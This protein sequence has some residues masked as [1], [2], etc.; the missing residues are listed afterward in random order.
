MSFNKILGQEAAIQ[1]LRGQ[2]KKGRV[3]HTY[4]FA[5]PEGIGKRLLAIEMAKALSC[6]QPVK[7]E[8]CD[9]CD[10]CRKIDGG[11]APNLICVSAEKGSGQIGI[12]PIRALEHGMS[13]TSYGGGWKIGMV[14]GAERLT[15]EAAN[16]C[17]KLLEEP[18]EKSLYL[19]IS[20]APHR[21]PAT[22]LSRCHTVRCLPQG[23]QRVEAYLKEKEGLAAALARMAA[24][25]SSGRIGLAL[26]FCRTDQLKEKNEILDQLLGARKRGELEIPLSKAGRE[27]I[28]QA[29]QWYAG[30]WRD[31]LIL[32]LKGDPEW[33]IHQDRL[34]DLKAALDVIARPASSGAKQSLR[35]PSVFL[36]QIE[37]TYWVQDAIQKNANP[38]TALAALLAC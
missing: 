18:S 13:L 12:D 9:D 17:L 5:G 8:A 22:L 20:S 11:S 25:C 7:G 38:R 10:S 21:L 33:I 6:A 15:D 28:Q 36:S 2:I 3:A 4:L 26:Q 27:E 35:N 16:A 37:R 19:L 1:L 30:W 24:N 32:S 29:L 31:L 23:V 14:D 34:E